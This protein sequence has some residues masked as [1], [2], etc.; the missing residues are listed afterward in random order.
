MK[1][2]KLISS[3]LFIAFTMVFVSCSDDDNGTIEPTNIEKSIAVL[4][5][6]QSGD[7]T[8]MQDYISA[9]TY[10]QHNL[11]YPDGAAAVIGATQSGAFSGTTIN[12]VR[13]F[14][15]DD[16]VVLHSEY[17]GTWNGGTP[18]AVFDV[19]RFQNGL[20][21][22]HWDN[23][24]NISDDGDGTTQLNGTLTPV[25][26]LGQ[27]TANRAIITT[28]GQDFFLN[29]EYTDSSFTTFFNESEFVQHSVSAGT[30]ITGLKGFVQNVLGEGTPFY[31][32]IEFIHVEGNFALM[33]SQG[34]PDATS[35]LASAYYDLFRLENGK[36]VEHWDVVQTIP[37]EA[38]WANSNGKW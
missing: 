17:G 14:Q 12:T 13:S 10:I 6:I 18:Q 2:S 3:I 7:V 23:L 30:D 34:F 33:Q 26:D 31:Q 9:T 24:D 37:A 20:I 22:E 21:V 25:A 32:S 15:D 11:S 4:Q 27:T 29:G 5:A 19:F 1:K 38:D 35:G 36:I 16:I 8:A 28:F